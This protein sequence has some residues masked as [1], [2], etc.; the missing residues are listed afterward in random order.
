MNIKNV[1]LIIWVMMIFAGGICAVKAQED[2]KITTPAANGTVLNNLSSIGGTAA[3]GIKGVRIILAKMESD[4]EWAL[5]RSTGRYEWQTGPT[6]QWIEAN[7]KGTNWNIP[8]GY[9]PGSANLRSG[10]KYVIYATF[11]KDDSTLSKDTMVHV[12]FTYQP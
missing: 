5:N 12:W 8:S 9:V 4:E 3:K 2:V 6:G 1:R 11:K 10:E 7:L